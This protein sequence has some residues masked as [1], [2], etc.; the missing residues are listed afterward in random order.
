MVQNG[1]ADQ[2]AEVLA[3]LFGEKEAKAEGEEQNNTAALTQ[4]LEGVYNERRELGMNEPIFQPKAKQQAQTPK[5]VAAE[6]DLG[7]RQKVRV[8]SDPNNNALLIWGR[9]SD[10]KKSKMPFVNWTSSQGRYSLKSTSLR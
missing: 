2:L 4:N 6:L 8:V 3:K 1:R 10:Y 9:E 5:A 7:G